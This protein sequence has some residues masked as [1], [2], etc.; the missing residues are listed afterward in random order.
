MQS[1][2]TFDRGRQNFVACEVELRAKRANGAIMRRTARAAE[3]WRQRGDKGA[4]MNDKQLREI[5]S[6]DLR[7]TAEDNSSKYKMTTRKYEGR[8]TWRK[9]NDDKRQ[10]SI[11]LRRSGWSKSELETRRRLLEDLAE[12]LSPS[13]HRSLSQV[14]LSRSLSRGVPFSLRPSHSLH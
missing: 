13:K 5:I 4:V 8:P 9:K 7:A 3:N 1:Q 6:S 11:V 10:K 12:T 14:P 2:E